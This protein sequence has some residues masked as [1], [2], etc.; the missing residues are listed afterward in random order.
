MSNYRMPPRSKPSDY[1]K[2]KINQDEIISLQIAN[3]ANI[4]AARKAIKMG[5]TPQLTPAQ[6]MSPEE[7]L[8]DE[9]AQEATARS[10]IEKLGFR[11]QEA[12]LII[13]EIRNDAELD[14]VQLNSNFPSLEADLKKRFNVKLLTPTF[15]VEYFRK[16]SEELAGAAG[17]RIFNP[18]NQGLNGLINTVAELR[19]IIPDPLVIDY[20]RQAAQD[21]RIVGQD[22]LQQLD[23]LRDL[24]PTARDLQALQNLN[25]VIQQR[26]MNDLLTQF[27]NMPSEAEIRR[28]G[29]MIQSDQLDRVAFFNAVKSL[30]D[31][32]PQGSQVN[33]VGNAIGSSPLGPGAPIVPGAPGETATER[34]ERLKN[35]RDLKA[36]QS[37]IDS[38]GDPRTL[39]PGAQMI[40]RQLMK[41][42]SVA[43]TLEQLK[44]SDSLSSSTQLDNSTLAEIKA[45]FKAN[46]SFQPLLFEFVA[47]PDGRPRPD[48]SSGPLNYNDLTKSVK[49]LRDFSTARKPGQK[50]F[51]KNTNIETLFQR[52][53]GTGFIK[54]IPKKDPKLRVGKGISVEQAP[55]FKE[56][57]KYAIHIPQLEN[58]DILNVKYK[59]LGQIPKY[60]PIAVSDVFRDFIIDLLQNGKPNTRVYSQICPEER[61]Y[62][63]EMS[64]GAGVWNGFGLKRTTT[65]EEDNENKRFE[66]L[67]GEYLAGNNN[68]KILTELRKLVVK[69]MNDGRIRKAEGINLLMELS[70]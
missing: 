38:N 56:Y 3:D 21:N 54:S 43:P 9:A 57:G 46:P 67:K 44:P 31:A 40:Y 34:S 8:A 60:K 47:G 63:E 10:N 49:P 62:F 69:M 35:E 53:F 24:L 51:Y 11:P 58:Q 29:T 59:S 1:A 4:A 61:K 50:V 5:E 32:I 23:R 36:A 15:F 12:A 22:L 66:L 64:I 68:P 42:G 19:L 14:F 28:L 33:I 26:I 55:T 70:A 13:N 16:Y 52:K 65:S 7:M 37:V 39:N 41:V 45:T 6:A 27:A 30:V 17:M 18:N 2:G 48:T 20:I 25:P